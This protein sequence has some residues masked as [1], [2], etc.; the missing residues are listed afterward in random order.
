M[1]APF[2]KTKKLEEMSRAVWE[3]LCDG[4]GKCCMAKLEDADTGE[5]YWTSVACRLFLALCAFLLLQA[6]FN[7]FFGL[8]ALLL[9][10]ILAVGLRHQKR[11]L[12]GAAAIFVHSRVQAGR[13]GGRS[14]HEQAERGS[15]QC[16]RIVFHRIRLLTSGK[17]RRAANP[18]ERRWFRFPSNVGQVRAFRRPGGGGNMAT[19]RR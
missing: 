14:R 1:D 4:C 16:A 8:A 12:R 18:S 6:L 7:P 2:W 17:S 5:I 19:S 9:D 3:A 13:P 15:G 10:R 11:S